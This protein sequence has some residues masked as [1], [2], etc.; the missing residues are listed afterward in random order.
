MTNLSTLLSIIRDLE[1]QLH[2]PALRLDAERVEKLLHKD[3]EEIGHSGQC[4]NKSQTITALKMENDHPQILSEDFA[5]TMISTGTVLLRYKSF[6]LAD[7]NEIIR[8][9]ERS[10]IWL[11][12]SSGQNDSQWQMRFHQG[13]AIDDSE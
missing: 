1:T 6:Q 5:L 12:S 2:Q 11:L 10:S 4:Y 8:R 7:D 13:T 3:F 9:T